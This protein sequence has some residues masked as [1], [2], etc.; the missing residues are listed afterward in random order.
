MLF[1][2]YISPCW[3]SST[4]IWLVLV[5]V[6]YCAW[7][8]Q[9]MSLRPFG[10]CGERSEEVYRQPERLGASLTSP[11]RSPE[12][13]AMSSPPGIPSC[14]VYDVVFSRCLHERLW[15]RRLAEHSRIAYEGD[16]NKVSPLHPCCFLHAIAWHNVH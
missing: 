8:A 5:R 7:H 4:E 15:P 14:T 6:A 11:S 1:R 13:G 12:K 9:A 10:T 3:T 16:L 2:G